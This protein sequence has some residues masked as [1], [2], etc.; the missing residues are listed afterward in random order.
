M[1]MGHLLRKGRLDAPWI[2]PP[3]VAGLE[4][5]EPDRAQA[6]AHR[7]AA[8]AGELL[9]HGVARRIDARERELERRHPDR[10]FADRDLAAGAR[11]ADLDRRDDLVRLGIDA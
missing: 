2:E 3:D 10:S 7:V 1:G 6:D 11:D 8:L 5:R 9:H 4:V